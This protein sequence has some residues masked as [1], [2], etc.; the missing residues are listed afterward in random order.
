MS[1]EIE[2]FGEGGRLGSRP[3]VPAPAAA[4]EPA[5]QW[6]AEPVADRGRHRQLAADVSALCLLPSDLLGDDLEPAHFLIVGQE[7]RRVIVGRER[8]DAMQ[9]FVKQMFGKALLEDLA[10]DAGADLA[11]ALLIDLVD[12]LIGQGPNRRKRLPLVPVVDAM[13]PNGERAPHSSV[14]SDAGQHELRGD[15]H[16]VV[17]SE[18]TSQ[19][20]AIP[21]TVCRHREENP[22][23]AATGP[24]GRHTPFL[25]AEKV[26]AQPQRG[27]QD[28]VRV[29][30]LA[31]L[32]AEP[33]KM[34][35]EVRKTPGAAG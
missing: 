30:D 19:H 24:Q 31:K 23:L 32:G 14:S 6:A 35:K 16:L 34:R 13:R 15:A 10:I 11:D 8:P 28:L 20:R 29:A 9:N 27:P 18:K 1:V 5:N 3:V 22:G 4:I 21:P 25:S 12:Q 26:E 17:S 33:P 7:S 2:Q